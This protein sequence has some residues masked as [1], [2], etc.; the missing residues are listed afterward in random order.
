MLLTGAVE[1]QGKRQPE[2]TVPLL[3]CCTTESCPG[4]GARQHAAMAFDPVSR[5]LV[6]FGG[7][8]GERVLG[9][10]WVWDGGAWQLLPAS[11]GPAPRTGGA[12]A[13][14]PQRGRLLLFGGEDR[15]G[16]ALGDLWEYLGPPSG[17]RQVEVPGPLPQARVFAAFSTAPVERS[18]GGT[19]LGVLLFGGA[20][21]GQPLGD[22]WV[23]LGR[24]G[25]WVLRQRGLCD[26]L[27]TSTPLGPPCRAG[28][29]LALAMGRSGLEALLVGGAGRRTAGG[30]MYDERVW[31]WDGRQWWEAQVAQ[32]PGVLHRRDH[33]LVPL[34]G[35]HL[36]LLGGQTDG[37]VRQDAFRLDLGRGLFV[38]QLGLSPSGRAGAAA[39]LDEERGELLLTGGWTEQGEAADTWLYSEP[40]GWVPLR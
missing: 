10:T 39:A 28:A 32:P 14:D 40:A 21:G 4:P 37:L 25:R 8:R 38:P 24:A 26:E 6:L 23:W 18:E 33:R 22:T 27:G 5:R 2:H 11:D 31:R 7:R 29:A 12:L 13:W 36:L 9:D 17:W 34:G 16:E 19:E 1:W 30:W 35:S 3:R 20:A 15:T